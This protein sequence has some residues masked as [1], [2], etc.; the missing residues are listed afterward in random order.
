MHFRKFTYFF[1]CVILPTV[2]L[3]LYLLTYIFSVCAGDST[4]ESGC[5][6]GNHEEVVVGDRLDPKWEFL[7]YQSRDGI[8]IRKCRFPGYSDVQFFFCPKSA[9]KIQT[10]FSGRI[11]PP[12]PP[13]GPNIFVCL[14]ESPQEMICFPSTQENIRILL[15]NREIIAQSKPMSIQEIRQV[16]NAKLQKE[17]LGPEITEK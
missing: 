6:V 15:M 9:T 16:Q 2:V 1:L 8:F 11:H 14:K 12:F 4:C 10:R 13:P 3:G 5:L 17:L 7:Y